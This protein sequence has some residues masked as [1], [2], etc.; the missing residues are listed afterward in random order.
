MP[1]DIECERDDRFMSLSCS[2]EAFDRLARL[3]IEESGSHD[4]VGDDL[5]RLRY[6]EIIAPARMQG[7][8]TQAESMSA[9][10]WGCFT[11]AVIVAGVCV[12]AM[13]IGFATIFGRF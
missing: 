4:K 11:V 2:E 7:D 6:I 8:Q 3:L 12:T 9:L 5:G 13:M 1:E 10:A